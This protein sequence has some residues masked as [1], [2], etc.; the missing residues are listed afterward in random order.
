MSTTSDG[1]EAETEALPAAP[2]VMV[3]KKT[4]KKAKKLSQTALDLQQGRVVEQG[5]HDELAV[6]GGLYARLV[7]SQAFAAEPASAMRPTDS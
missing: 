5:T 6:A 2:A 3:E 4:S 7:R 1:A